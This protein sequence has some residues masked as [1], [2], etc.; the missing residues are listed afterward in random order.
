MKLQKLAPGVLLCSGLLLCAQTARKP[1]TPHRDQDNVQAIGKLEDE[2]RI[3]VLKG[4]A[5]WWVEHLSEGYTGT[6]FQGK[7]SNRDQTIELQ[8]ST[9]LVY[10]A[11]NLSDRAVHTFNGDT[12]IVT[13]KVTVEGTYRGQS[14]SG[15][16]QFTRVW[17]KN[18][19]VWELA[20]AQ[21]T[22]IGS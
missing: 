4:T 21:Y 17:V 9:D 8:R 15:D 5:G 14:L 13:G 3:A 7:V 6:D 10:D 1:A 19:L 12:V 22:K 16:F 20:A 18:G 11:W 2:M